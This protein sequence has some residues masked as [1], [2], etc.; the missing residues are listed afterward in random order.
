MTHCVFVTISFLL[1]TKSKQKWWFFTIS[2]YFRRV[3]RAVVHVHDDKVS[4]VHNIE[5]QNSNQKWTRHW[6][7][8]VYKIHPLHFHF[9]FQHHYHHSLSALF[10]CW[11]NKKFF[12]IF[13]MMIVGYFIIGNYLIQALI[14]S[15]FFIIPF[16]KW[17][18][19]RI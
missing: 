2:S 7:T 9:H 13:M 18:W 4:A 3:A 6:F 15:T 14:K 17:F 19:S 8:F 16:N 11:N 5:P 1:R 12:T 10:F